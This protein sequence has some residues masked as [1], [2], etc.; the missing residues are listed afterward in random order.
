M[1]FVSDS[2]NHCIRKI[3]LEQEIVET[4]AGKCE[5]S[6]FKDGPTVINRFYYPGMMGVNN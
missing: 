5:V 1:L 2:G 6:G 3:Y 4:Y